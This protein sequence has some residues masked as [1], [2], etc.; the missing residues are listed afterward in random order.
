MLPTNLVFEMMCVI[1]CGRGTAIEITA[2]FCDFAVPT[3]TVTGISTFPFD[4]P[5]SIPAGMT[6]FNW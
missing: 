1:Y 4:P 3:W 6:T 5:K 2:L